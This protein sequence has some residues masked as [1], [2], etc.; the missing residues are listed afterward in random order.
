MRSVSNLFTSPLAR[1][2]GS[3]LRSPARKNIAAASLASCL[4]LGARIGPLAAEAAAPFYL[5]GSGWDLIA[6]EPPPRAS[7]GETTQTTSPSPASY[8]E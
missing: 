5:M 7:A 4:A 6:S 3:G 1:G 2:G 8:R